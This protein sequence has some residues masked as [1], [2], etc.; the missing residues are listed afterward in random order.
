MERTAGRELWEAL[1]QTVRSQRL[2]E[3][4]VMISELVGAREGCPFEPDDLDMPVGVS[5]GSH[6]H[7]HREQAQELLVDNLPY[8][9]SHVFDGAA[10]NV[11]STNSREFSE[12]LT[13]VIE[14][15]NRR[16]SS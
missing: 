6:S 14:G 12:L 7:G 1:P 16:H 4:P 3:V 15:V 10:H 11:Q 8:A 5:R 13:S 9:R 2:S